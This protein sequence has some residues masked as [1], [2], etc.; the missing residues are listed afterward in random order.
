MSS[1]L[2]HATGVFRRVFGSVLVCFLYYFLDVCWCCD[3]V[4]GACLSELV[5]AGYAVCGGCGDGVQLL[6]AFNVHDAVAY[7]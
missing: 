2:T 3:E 7:D 6:S 5:L 4:F 1:C